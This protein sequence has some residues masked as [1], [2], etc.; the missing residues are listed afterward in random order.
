LGLTRSQPD[1]LIAYVYICSLPL[2]IFVQP[3]ANLRPDFQH[4]LRLDRLLGRVRHAGDPAVRAGAGAMAPQYVQHSRC[5]LEY[6]SN[7]RIRI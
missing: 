1:S 5:K 4:P 2:P 3:D 6:Y 7:A